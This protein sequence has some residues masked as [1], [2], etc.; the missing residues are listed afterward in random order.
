MGII[1]LAYLTFKGLRIILE[2]NGFYAW[3]EMF[4]SQQRF[5]FILSLSRCNFCMN[6]HLSILATIIVGLLTGFDLFYLLLPLTSA[7]IENLLHGR[8]SN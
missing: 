3:F 7:T 1:L 2:K 4:A 6:H 8:S 5:K